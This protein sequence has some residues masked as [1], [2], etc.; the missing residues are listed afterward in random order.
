MLCF[1]VITGFRELEGQI[2][3]VRRKLGQE[4]PKT[5]EE[6]P[7]KH[8]MLFHFGFTA[9]RHLVDPLPTTTTSARE[10]SEDQDWQIRVP[11]STRGCIRR[12]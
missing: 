4:G 12:L 3:L 2:P 11:P 1:P 6:F 7:K 9:L 8:D 5:F 10:G